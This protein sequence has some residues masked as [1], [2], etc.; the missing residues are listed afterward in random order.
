[1]KPQVFTTTSDSGWVPALKEGL[2]AGSLAS[3][4][5]TAVLAGAGRRETGSAFAPINAVSHW[6]WGD[7]AL[8]VDAPTWRH[9]ALG[10]LTNHAAAIFW[11]VLYAKF[12]QRTRWAGTLPGAV[13]GGIAT[14]AAASAIDYTVVPK[15]LTPGYEH[16]LS[17]TSMVGVFGAIAAG[18][19]IGSLLLR[20][21]D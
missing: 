16:R 19:A 8:R 14:S 9:T 11:A 6:V 1:M 17:T 3:L 13:L 12:T 18:I 7:E 2:V 15:R 5:S 4:L 20:E 21:R 10:L